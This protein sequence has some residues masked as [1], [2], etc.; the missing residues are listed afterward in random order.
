M[1]NH[2]SFLLKESAGYVDDPSQFTISSLLGKHKKVKGQI[3]LEIEVE[4]NKFPKESPYNDEDSSKLIPKVWKYTHDG[5]LRGNDNAEYILRQP[6][7]FNEVPDA[8]NDLWGMF[9]DYGSVLDDSHRTSVHVHLNALDWHLNRVAAFAGL[10]FSVEEILTSWCGDIRV[11]NLFCLRAKDAPAIIGKLREFLN[12]GMMSVFDEGLHYAAFN[13]HSLTDKGSIEIRTMRGVND[14]NVILVWVETLQHIYELSKEYSDPRGVCE[15]F[16]G[17]GYES[18]IKTVIGPH[19]ERI[20]KE[21]N[22][23]PEEIQEAMY[24]GIRMAQ[25]ICY[26]RDWSKF[27][28]NE[29]KPDPFGRSFNKLHSYVPEPVYI[30][31]VPSQNTHNPSQLLQAY[32]QMTQLTQLAVASPDGVW[33]N[34]P[35]PAATSEPQPV[36]DWVSVYDEFQIPE[37]EDLDDEEI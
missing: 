7:M 34:A 21:C 13:A 26:C 16:S 5:S 29:M 18:Y 2:Q 12:T 4:G 8:L 11:G 37:Q 15:G 24:R 22:M 3:G 28:K 25:N 1:P 19:W 35:V 33:F 20:I 6:I 14:P 10:Y 23:S 36:H 32:Q 30:E 17:F 27:K 31:P 9:K